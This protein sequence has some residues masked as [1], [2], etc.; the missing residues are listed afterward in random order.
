[1]T[2]FNKLPIVS[3]CYVIKL[4]LRGLYEVGARE[5]TLRSHQCL[6]RLMNLHSLAPVGK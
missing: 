6:T 5:F 2:K 4:V 3:R 1:M